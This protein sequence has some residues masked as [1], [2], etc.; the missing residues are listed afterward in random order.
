MAVLLTAFGMTSLVVAFQSNITDATTSS[1]RARGKLHLIQMVSGHAVLTP[2]TDGFVVRTSDGAEVWLAWLAS[3]RDGHPV[4]LAFTV[5]RAGAAGTPFLLHSHATGVT[6]VH[7]PS[8]RM[9]SRLPTLT[10]GVLPVSVVSMVMG[11]NGPATDDADGAFLLFIA[12]LIWT[13]LSMWALGVAGRRYRREFE[14]SVVAPLV[15]DVGPR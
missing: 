8:V 12:G 6:Y 11:C 9:L 5:A 14:E 1:F 2:D 10:W 4:T 3:V 15:G 13:F 7:Y